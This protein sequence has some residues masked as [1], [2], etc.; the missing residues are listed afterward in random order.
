MQITLEKLVGKAI[1][2]GG[3]GNVT[4]TLL[5]TLKKSDTDSWGESDLTWDEVE[6]LSQKQSKLSE[7]LNVLR[8]CFNPITYAFFWRDII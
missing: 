8:E 1:N 7:A 6:G 3:V 4:W 5:K 2:V